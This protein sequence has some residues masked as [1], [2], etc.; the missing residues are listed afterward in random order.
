MKLPIFYEVNNMRYRVKCPSCGK[1]QDIPA[2]GNCGCGAPLSVFN[3]GCIRIYRMGN[4]IGIAVGMGIYI[5]NQPYGLLGNTETVMIPLSAGRHLLHMTHGMNR[6]CTDVTFD[7]AP[8]S[9]T[10]LCYKAHIRMGA[11]SNTVVIEPARFEDMP[12]VD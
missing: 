11:F 8:G 2:N 10:L 12:H 4:P 6:R 9:N 7:I 5:D 3:D 1:V